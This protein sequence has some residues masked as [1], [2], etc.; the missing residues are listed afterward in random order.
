M[1]RDKKGTER[2]VGIWLLILCGYCSGKNFA[3]TLHKTVS[4]VYPVF[5]VLTFKENNLNFVFIPNSK[6]N[7]RIENKR[8]LIDSLCKTISHFRIKQFNNSST[9][10]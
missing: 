9:L 10:I 8:L 7:I 3:M 2:D 4:S 6:A 5:I 1:A